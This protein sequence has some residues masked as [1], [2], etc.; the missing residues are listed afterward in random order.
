M[1]DFWHVSSGFVISLLTCGGLLWGSGRLASRLPETI[2]G[3]DRFAATVA[4]ALLQVVVVTTG[5]GAI[6]ALHRW[7]AL[8]VAL[9]LSGGLALAGGRPPSASVFRQ[10][11]SSVVEGVR[12]ER[13][14]LV[15]ALPGL[16]VLTL[17]FL[18]ALTRPPLGYDALNYHLPLA[19]HYL[20]AHDLSL[21]HFPAYYDPYPYFPAVGELFSVWA[22]ILFGCDLWMPLV[23]LPFLVLLL[24]SLYGLCRESGTTRIAATAVA[25]SLSTVPAVFNILTE[26]YVELPLWAAFLASLRWS[27][28]AARS[29]NLLPLMLAAGLAGTLPGIK[30]VGWIMA[31]LVLVFLW[32]A[33]LTANADC[34]S[35]RRQG[36]RRALLLFTASILVFGAGFYVRNWLATGNPVYPY[37]VAILGFDW[38]PGLP[39]I[40]SRLA[41]TSLFAHLGFLWD[42]G[43]LFQAFVGQAG[44]PNSSW[45]L[46]PVGV[47]SIT[48]GSAAGLWALWRSLFDRESRALRLQA[49]LFLLGLVLIGLY[50]LL[51]RSGTFVFSNVRF[52]YPGV[53][54]LALAGVGLAVRFRNPRAAIPVVFVT[55]QLA[56]F[57]AFTNIPVTLASGLTTGGLAILAAL[58]LLKGTTGS[59]RIRCFPEITPLIRKLTGVGLV[60]AAG[61]AVQGLHQERNAGRIQEYS[62]KP[63]PYQFDYRGYAPCL[64]ALDEALPTGRLALAG[65]RELNGFVSPWFG[66]HLE[67]EI[68]VVDPPPHE[69]GHEPWADQITATGSTTLMIFLPQDRSVSSSES[70]WAHTHPKRFERLHGSA[71]CELYRMTSDEAAAAHP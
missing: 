29:S 43:K 41:A 21:F 35:H 55:C 5:L 14:I 4:I 8:P 1:E 48:V 37:P 28:H 16:L 6:G 23:N 15:V 67:R 33:P 11:W 38:F 53:V 34:A 36:R 69:R 54:L 9:A 62:R 22:F 12:A 25:L 60:V 45:G 2:G 44:V 57:V 17:S 59:G 65:T 49:M 31:P 42:S 70:A 50:A 24:L 10:A 61:V 27:L 30:Q 64:Q 66:A 58:I 19:A 47:L 71:F 26:S 56:G 32:L 7:A 68:R 40:G 39:G 3:I 51:P 20:Q 18:Y 13:A 46:G 52:V 63:L